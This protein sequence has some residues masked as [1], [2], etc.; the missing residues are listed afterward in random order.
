MSKHLLLLLSVGGVGEEECSSAGYQP[1]A[2]AIAATSWF[3]RT[4]FFKRKRIHK[5]KVITC[6][7]VLM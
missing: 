4:Y 5:N 6:R 2:V 3:R 1:G 7:P